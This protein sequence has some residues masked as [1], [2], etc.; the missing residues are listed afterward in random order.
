MF[1]CFHRQSVQHH[2]LGWLLYVCKYEPWSDIALSLHCRHWQR[3]SPEIIGVLDGEVSLPFCPWNTSSSTFHFLMT[4]PK[5][6]LRK[7][8]EL[9][10]I[11]QNFWNLVAEKPDDARAPVLWHIP[12]LETKCAPCVIHG[13]SSSSSW[14]ERFGA[15]ITH[16]KVLYEIQELFLMQSSAN[17]YIFGIWPMMQYNCLLSETLALFSWAQCWYTQR[18]WRK[19]WT[20]IFFNS[21]RYLFSFFIY[22]FISDPPALGS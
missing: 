20:K 1:R 7:Y 10:S 6:L 3:F 2:N 11:Y 15:D 17:S 14:E 19:T 9:K 18:N 5:I 21:S 8:L 16:G 4:F 12:S 22:I 13:C